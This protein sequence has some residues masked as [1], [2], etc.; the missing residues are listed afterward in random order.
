MYFKDN[1]IPKMPGKHITIIEHDLQLKLYGATNEWGRDIPEEGWRHYQVN[2]DYQDGKGWDVIESFSLAPK[3]NEK[4]IEFIG[5]AFVE[6]VEKEYKYTKKELQDIHNERYWASQKKKRQ[7]QE[8]RL[9]QINEEKKEKRNE[10]G[11]VYSLKE[12]Q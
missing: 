3:L 4:W 10:P 2:K 1:S 9:K 6:W 7:A 12:E 11:L 8:E 5:K